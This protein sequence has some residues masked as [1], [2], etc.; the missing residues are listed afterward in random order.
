MIFDWQNVLTV[1]IV[2][3]AAAYV[4]RQVVRWV[5]RKGQPGCGGC[6]QCPTEPPEEP[7]VKIDQRK[8]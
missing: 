8:D 3:L 6:F 1:F 2:L 4:G 7:L 5:K